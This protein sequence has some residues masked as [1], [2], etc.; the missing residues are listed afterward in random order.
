MNQNKWIFFAVLSEYDVAAQAALNQIA[1]RE[2]VELIVGTYDW[3]E[4]LLAY[5]EETDFSYRLAFLYIPIS[6]LDDKQMARL[7][8]NLGKCPNLKISILSHQGNLEAER[9]AWAKNQSL[10]LIECL[11]MPKEETQFPALFFKYI[12]ENSTFKA[13]YNQA[14]KK[15]PH[16]E[17]KM[18]V[19]GGA[20]KLLKATLT[21]LEKPDESDTIHNAESSAAKHTQ[22]KDQG[23]DLTLLSLMKDI[24]IKKR[25]LTEIS[26][27]KV[28]L[29]EKELAIAEQL[30]AKGF[31]DWTTDEQKLIQKS[32]R[33]LNAKKSRQ[34]RRNLLIFVLTF[35]L[36]I[37]GLFAYTEW[38]A[39]K[40]KLEAQLVYSKAQKSDF[41]AYIAERVVDKDATE[42]VRLAEAACL[43]QPTFAA[44]RSLYDFFYNDYLFYH[45]RVNGEFNRAY[46]SPNGMQ[47]LV[48]A[49]DKELLQVYNNKNELLWEH[50]LD[51][52][53]RVISY[54]PDGKNIAIAQADGNVLLY[55]ASGKNMGILALH[56]AQI[57]SLRFSPDG[58]YLLSAA[59]D[60]LVQLVQIADKQTTALEGSSSGVQEAYFLG[61]NQI[62]S[63]SADSVLT[64]WDNEGM[65][66]KTEQFREA[67]QLPQQSKQLTFAL[68]PKTNAIFTYKA[69]GYSLQIN[70]KQLLINNLQTDSLAL[71]LPWQAVRIG[72]SANEQSIFVQN[73]DGQIRIYS[74]NE[75]YIG[76]IDLAGFNAEVVPQFSENG[77]TLLTHHSKCVVLWSS[78][79]KA[80]YFG[81]PAADICFANDAPYFVHY[82]K[83]KTPAVLK[84]YSTDGKLLNQI[85]SLGEAAVRQVHSL[86]QG[87]FAVETHNGEVLLWNAENYSLVNLISPEEAKDLQDYSLS[88]HHNFLRLQYSNKLIIKDL[89]QRS[90]RE[91]KVSYGEFHPYENSLLL[92]Q[93][94]NSLLLDLDRNDT[95]A[96]INIAYQW[97]R[98]SPQGSFI[99]GTSDYKNYAIYSTQGERISGFE[100]P[101]GLP[102][103]IKF[104]ANDEAILL[105]RDTKQGLLEHKA[106]FKVQNAKVTLLN[107]QLKRPAVSYAE[108]SADG[109]FLITEINNRIH[110]WDMYGNRKETFAGRAPYYLKGQDLLLSVTD[111]MLNIRNQQGRQIVNIPQQGLKK[112]KVSADEKLMAL[113]FQDHIEVLPVGFPHISEWLSKQHIATL[114]KQ[115]KAE[116]DLE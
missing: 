93:A 7:A 115:T 34:N 66:K 5:L 38:L 35:I 98:F 88:Y 71:E 47:F 86:Q 74:P 32:R 33:A 77:N 45:T 70:D 52:P 14:A 1:E 72:F 63:L 96:H 51:A 4:M 9:I 39:F 30:T 95:L 54:S 22:N 107:P 18:F 2:E 97:L 109:N 78:H 64:Y 80:A 110:F 48:L 113:F 69:E 15:V 56:K 13:A 91:W 82:Q 16:A 11:E 44:Q 99:I 60:S 100:T 24:F 67:K 19:K 111:Y 20:E 68:E 61:K 46:I 27:K 73:Q 10:L 36:F 8:A 25:R 103:Q 26:K 31:E 75:G 43:Y 84:L 94:T 105:Y 50:S 12:N 55:E 116:F 108:F 65:L 79:R 23:I 85:D 76:K 57:N 112:I 28:L 53:A 83:D 101:D 104:A 106:I 92:Q 21:T 114:S 29:Q 17:A 81:T 90:E 59:Q 58:K 87:R 40:T 89:T 62:L 37:F 49:T 6:D 41:L 102:L 3:I 42:S